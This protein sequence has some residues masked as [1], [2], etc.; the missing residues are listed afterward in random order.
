MNER[1]RKAIHTGW[2]KSVWVNF[3]CLPFKQAIHLPIIV[4]R[5]TRLHI[6]SRQC[7]S[8]PDSG[9][10]RVGIWDDECLYLNNS[11]HIEGKLVIKGSGPHLFASGLSLRIYKGAVL[12]LGDNFYCGKNAFIQIHKELSI[13]KDN[14]WSWDETVIDSDTHLIFD[15][16]RRM[17]SKNKEV[18]FGDHVWLGCRSIVLKGAAIPS[19]CIVAAGSIMT[20]GCKY[21]EEAVIS[22]KGKIIRERVHWDRKI[23]L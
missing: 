9:R 1:F 11:L 5:N 12:E 15:S 7:I 18:R 17:I 13:G 16:E 2:I 6:A 10:L 19:G 3:Y 8:I 22:S 4:S 23:N 20:S 21:P 14:V